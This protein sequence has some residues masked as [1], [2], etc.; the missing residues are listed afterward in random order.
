MTPSSASSARAFPTPRCQPGTKPTAGPLT[1]ESVLQ[2]V[3]FIRSWEPTALDRRAAALAGDPARGAAI[4]SNVCFICHGQNGVG[5]DRA[6]ALNDPTLLAQFDDAWFKD[7]ITAGRPAQGMPTWG[8][9]LSPLQ[10]G[11]LLALIDQWRTAAN[12]VVPTPAPTEAPVEIARPSN[13]GGPGAALNL[14]GT[15]TAG[16]EVFVANC[17]KCHGPDGQGGVNNPG[18]DDGTVPP[19][20]PID[21]TL[22]NSDVAGLRLQPGPVPGARLHTQRLRPAID[23]AGLGRPAETDPAADRGRDGLCH[24]LEPHHRRPHRPRNRAAIQSRRPRRCPGPDRRSVNRPDG[25]CGQLS[26]VSR[27]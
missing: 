23:H 10:I 13:S 9:V 25:I 5:T 3:A 12:V 20:N 2:L 26:E 22:V 19:L 21:S 1:D 24:Q 16:Q 27:H 6:P 4:F 17:Q 11:D 7:T 14:T 8:T 18:S 15:V